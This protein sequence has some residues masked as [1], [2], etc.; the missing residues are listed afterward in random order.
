[1]TYHSNI[2][3]LAVNIDHIENVF[4]NDAI[5]EGNPNLEEHS[6]FY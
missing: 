3:Y 1:M 2:I 5:N 4:V 6:F